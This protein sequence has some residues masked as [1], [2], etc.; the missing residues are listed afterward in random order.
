MPNSVFSDIRL[1]NAHGPYEH[2]IWSSDS[3][4]FASTKDLAGTM[5]FYRRSFDLVESISKILVQIFGEDDIR[6]KTIVDVGC[7]DGWILHMLNERFSF[8]RAVGVEPRI[9]NITK[10]QVARAHHR[11]ECSVHF[12]QGSIDDLDKQ[13][14]FE[15]FDIVLNLGTLHHVGSTPDAIQK[16][17]S[18]CKRLMI[19]DSMVVDEPRKEFKKLLQLLNL[20]DV[21]YK[22]MPKK[23]AIAAFKFESPYLDGS[24]AGSIIVNVPEKRL[25]EMSLEASGMKLVS[26][27]TTEAGFYSPKLQKLRGV[28]EAMV[29]AEKAN[30]KDEGIVWLE[31][32]IQ[33]EQENCFEVVSPRV[34]RHWSDALEG[35]DRIGDLLGLASEPQTGWLRT[36]VLYRFSKKPTS[37]L[38][39][40]CAKLLVNNNSELELLANISRSPRDKV[41]LELGKTLIKNGQYDIAKDVLISILDHIGADWRCFYRASFLLAFV[42]AKQG[43]LAQSDSYLQLTRT[44]NPNWPLVVPEEIRF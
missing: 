29:V 28:R 33:H 34:L 31:G 1:L 11:I 41:L 42:E 21:I 8:K 2:G 4:S 40:S 20:K 14:N 15:S 35:N 16:L 7:Y 3:N 26:S 18:I 37:W 30:A 38:L 17:S 19:V 12:V 44:A 24:S 6:D 27:S 10:G 5:L 36:Y 32:A 23:W 22:T 43:N 13:P 39:R 25:I 9:K